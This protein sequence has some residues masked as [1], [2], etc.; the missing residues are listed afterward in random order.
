MAKKDIQV[1]TRDELDL[2]LV[3]FKNHLDGD[4]DFTFSIKT[5][6]SNDSLDVVYVATRGD[7]YR[8]IRENTYK[9]VHAKTRFVFWK[10]VN[11]NEKIFRNK[12]Q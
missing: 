8:T 6:N 1:K 5:D 2:S 12:N 9:G 7:I 10:K 4:F 3:N 11:T